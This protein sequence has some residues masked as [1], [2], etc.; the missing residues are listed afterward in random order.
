MEYCQLAQGERYV[1]ARM[2][3]QGYSYREIGRVLDRAVSTISREKQRNLT[4][5]DGRYRAEKAHQYAMAR[6]SR[7]VQRSITPFID[8]VDDGTMLHQHLYRR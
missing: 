2:M 4:Q 5:H 1:M 6:R 8:G 7:T 3:H